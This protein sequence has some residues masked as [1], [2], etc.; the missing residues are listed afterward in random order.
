MPSFSAPRCASRA[1]PRAHVAAVVLAQVDQPVVQPVLVSLPEL[2]AFRRDAEP[3]PVRGPRDLLARKALVHLLDGRLQ[4]GARGDGP[5]LL[6]GACVDTVLARSARPVRVALGFARV[7]DR[8]FE[9][10]LPVELVPVEVG[11]G[12]R[13]DAQRVALDFLSFLILLKRRIDG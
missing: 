10:D 1:E 12:A 3:A 13:V 5:A 4:R 2:D 9:A 11:A 6:A 7:R 8:A